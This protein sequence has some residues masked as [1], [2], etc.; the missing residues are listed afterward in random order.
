MPEQI[1]EFPARIYSLCWSAD[2]AG[3]YVA[4][5]LGASHND[6]WFVP[7][8]EPLRG[9]KKL[10][11]GQA[12]EDWPSISADGR[13]L[14]HTDNSENATA[15]VQRDLV[16]GE[17]RALSVTKFDPGEP[18]G[19]VTLRI[20]DAD[21]G[22]PVI[23]RV[24]VKQ[25]GG[26]FFAPPGALY[27]ITAGLGHFYSHGSE[28]LA[29]PA[30]RYEVRVFRGTEYR[31]ARTDFELRA[32]EDRE[33]PIQLERW[34]NA[35]AEGWI[36]GENHIHA[37]YGY[38]AWYNT[39]RT[40]FDLCNGEDLRVCNLVVANSDGD[41][42]F[43]REFFRGRPDPLSTPGAILYWNQEFRATLWGHM[44]LFDLDQLVEPV[45]TGFARTT[46]PWDVPTNADI[47]AR[48]HAQSGVASYTHPSN[49]IEDFYD[50]PY[51]AKGLP[52]D[53]A[54]R[55]IDTLDVMG[56]TYEPSV[57]FWYRLL[58]CGFRLPAAAGAD[59]FLNRIPV[60]PP[61][62]G[63]VYVRVAGE[64]T[65]D[66]WIAGLKAGESFISNGPMLDLTANELAPGGTLRLGSPGGVRVKGR[67][68]SQLPLQR[69]EVVVNGEVVAR[70]DLAADQLAGTIDQTVPI[71]RSGWLALRTSGPAQPHWLGRTVAA[72]TNPVYVEVDG[73]P[74]DRREDA[75]YFLRWIDRLEAQFKQRN[76]V[77]PGGLNAVQLQFDAA[78]RAY[79][80]IAEGKPIPR[81]NRP[82]TD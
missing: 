52:V 1:A 16:S 75:G 80:A 77:P 31:V 41:G 73:R 57:P 76:R 45:F 61:G 53:A 68:R 55:R 63:R 2:G 20:L 18:A 28:T 21:S 82:P 23:A 62:W 58:N 71:E 43:D 38:G 65:Y 5:D 78:R 24:S 46:N 44:T 60:S 26:K 3:C 48:A 66:K 4:T 70:G 72:H 64:V 37:N 51:S 29:L 67:V 14:M 10:T 19:R 74:Q 54:L 35:A 33:I 40:I 30:G 42:V 36:S 22:R 59:C 7:F 27:R 11:H 49:N 25:S 12:D 34:V 56:F 15:L 79:R 17:T 47:A 50:Q 13:W 81:T 69:L 6:I 32:G 39:P 8:A 9:M